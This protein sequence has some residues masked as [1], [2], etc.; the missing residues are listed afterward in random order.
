MKR[1]LS[2]FAGLFLLAHTDARALSL[3]F[4]DANG[5]TPGAGGPTPTGTW[6]KD[7]FWSK[8]DTNGNTGTNVTGAWQPGNYAVFCAGNDAT[9]V[10]TV[11]VSGAIQVADIH[12][13]LGQITFNPAP[14]TN[15][16]FV[17]N[18]G[19]GDNTNR[20]LSVGQKDPNALARYNVPLTA[21]TNI[22][23]YKR[24]TVIFGA[25]NTYSGSTT[26]EGG[27]IQLAVPNAIPTNS[28]LVLANND[29]SAT[30]F[31]SAWQFTPA[32]FATGGFNQQFGTL[33]LNGTDPTVMRV[34]DFGNGA[35]AVTFDD[36]SGLDWA[37]YTLTLTNYTLGSDSLRFGTTSGGLTST[38]LGQIQFADF[39]NVPGVIDSH[40]F[41]TPA[42]PI[43]TSI[44]PSNDGSGNSFTINWTGIT[45][46]N[47]Q[48][49]STPSLNP[50]AWSN[51]S[52]II[53]GDNPTFTDELPADSVRYYRVVLLFP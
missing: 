12:V 19:T 31:N 3:Y 38:Q 6:G 53:S 46:R 33:L 32:V 27:I 30:D 51:L 17:L 44:V 47:Y 29:P 37:N 26:I 25:T 28:Q 22:T 16:S 40:G 35:S 8:D 41:V 5:T 49:Q 4:W 43:I 9:G 39:G 45:S 14:G 15:G 1:L 2:L 42:L 52:P 50:S 36:S 48:V 11:N 24:G 20:L 13:D 23:R 7:P 10:Y 34:I 18:D 21:A